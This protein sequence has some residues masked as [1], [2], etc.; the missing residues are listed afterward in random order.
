MPCGKGIH[1]FDGFVE[2]LPNKFRFKKDLMFGGE[3]RIQSIGS[4]E[5]SGSTR[6]AANTLLSGGIA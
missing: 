2:N 5:S 3:H 4:C 1:N 6:S